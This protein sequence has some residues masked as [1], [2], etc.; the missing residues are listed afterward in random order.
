MAKTFAKIATFTLLVLSI[1]VSLNLKLSYTAATPTV[2]FLPSNLVVGKPEDPFAPQTFNVNITVADVEDLFMWEVNVTFNP[3][4]LQVV[5]ILVPDNNVF[6]K[7]RVFPPPKIDNN[8]GYV[9]FGA[10]MQPGGQ[11]FYGSGLLGFIK[12]TTIALGSSDLK[13]VTVPEELQ[14]MYSYLIVNQLE[15][16]EIDANWVNGAVTVEGYMPT[17]IYTHVSLQPS[18][19]IVGGKQPPPVSLAVNVTVTNATDLVGWQVNVTFSPEILQVTNITRPSN[20]VF[21]NRT[22]ISTDPIIDNATGFVEWNVTLSDGEPAFN[23]N[24]TMCQIEFQGIVLGISNLT[25]SANNTYLL[26]SAHKK[27]SMDMFNGVVQV[28]QEFELAFLEVSPYK[29]EANATEPPTYY[30]VNVTVTNVT[31]LFE[32]S[33]SLE[34]NSSYVVVENMSRPIN[35]VFEG[36]EVIEGLR[37]VDN[38]GGHVLWGFTI[39]KG[40]SFYGNGT[41]CQIWFRGIAQ[42]ISNMTFGDYG[43]IGNTYLK[44]SNSTLINTRLIHAL[45]PPPIII[46]PRKAGIGWEIFTGPLGV[47][48]ILVIIYIAIKL[49]GRR[50]DRIGAEPIYY[51]EKIST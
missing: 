19:L 33:I 46:P 23:G 45:A 13:F 7:Y 4:I 51:K 12:F 11:T 35:D 6:G 24:G 43:L 14:S 30:L 40:L 34:F 16:N 17:P 42:G 28:I 29:I 50:L 38:T 32:W 44:N 48:I 36:R 1:F 37:D 31:D 3:K 25:F 9:V 26:N 47:V 5:S 2:S 20:D 41:L 39:S 15:L 8:V 49:R 22:V 27:I 18:Q 10:T 21:A